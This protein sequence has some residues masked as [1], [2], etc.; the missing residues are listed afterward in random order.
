M[1]L[2]SWRAIAAENEAQ[3]PEK[4]L[5]V[6]PRFALPRDLF[7]LPLHRE[8]VFGSDLEL[9]VTVRILRIISSGRAV[10]TEN[11]ANHSESD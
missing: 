3:H 6:L 2:G 4:R 8:E 1:I 10:A 7:T 11:K 9:E 5:V